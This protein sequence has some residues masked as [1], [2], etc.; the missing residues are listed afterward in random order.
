MFGLENG[1]NKNNVFEKYKDYIFSFKKSVNKKTE[2]KD[3][4]KLIKEIGADKSKVPERLS[5]VTSTCFLSTPLLSF[6]FFFLVIF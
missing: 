3:K 4:K 1:S 5:N 6:M 2:K